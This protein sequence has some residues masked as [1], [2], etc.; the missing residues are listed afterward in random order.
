MFKNGSKVYTDEDIYIRDDMLVFEAF[1]S[2]TVYA[3]EEQGEVVT[4]LIRE[5]GLLHE[6]EDVG[7]MFI[8]QH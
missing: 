1:K 7:H 2:Y 5:E 6:I 4:C 3:T 8:Y